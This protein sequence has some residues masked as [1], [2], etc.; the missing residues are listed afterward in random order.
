MSNSSPAPN[1]PADFGLSRRAMLA[2]TGTGFG[3]LGLAAMLE[4]QLTATAAPAGSSKNPLAPQAPHFAPKAKRVIFLFMNGGPSHV[5]SFDYKPKLQE[6]D[7]KTGEGQWNGVKGKFMGSPFKFEK[8]GQAGIEVSEIFPHI[9]NR[10]D[11]ICVINSMHTTT[12]NHEPGLFMMNCGIQQPTRPCMGSWLSYGL[13][14]ENQNLP[15]FVVLCPG[16]PVVGPALWSSSFLPGIYQGTHI[17]NAKIDPKKVIGHIN[18]QNLSQSS[19]RRLL[20]LMQK[21]NRDHLQS[22]GQDLALEARIES[23]EM[24]FRMQFE[25]QDAFDIGKESKPVR[26]SYGSGQFADGCLIARRLVERG[27]RMVQLFYGSGQPWDAHGN[28]MD[29]K[30]DAGKSDQPVAALIDDL[31]SRGLFDETLIIWSGEFGRTPTAQGAKGRNHHATGFTTWMAGGGVKGGMKYGATDELGIKAVENRVSVHD[32]HATIL[33]LLG[34]DHERLTYRY[35]GR[36]FRLTDVHGE[37]IH[38]IIA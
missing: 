13:G 12:P 14:S 30:R 4:S 6:M 17:N 21:L 31:K 32:L 20:D 22:R 3:T 15:G 5:D 35:S 19:Q 27:V 37:V 33:H 23:L 7:G 24:A 25:A 34:M 8:K 29:H 18:N 28:I 9:G 1:S 36:D 11:D 38:D 2:R 10:I 26:E 16:K